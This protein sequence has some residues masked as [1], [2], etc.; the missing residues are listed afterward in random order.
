MKITFLSPYLNMGGG[1]KVVSIYADF[2]K[3]AGHEVL[4][5][6]MPA[7]MPT[8][9]QRIKGLTAL[10]F[11]NKTHTCSYFDD[12]DLNIHM[13]NKNRPI[14]TSD[15]PDADIIIATWW[16]TAE[17]LEKIDVKKGK[18]VYLIQGYEVF[19][20]VPVS[21]AEAT[22]KTNSHKVVVSKWLKNII[23]TKYGN[24]HVDLVYNAIE[25]QYFSYLERDKNI[26][27]TIG[28][29]MNESSVKG[30]DVAF[31]VIEKLKAIYPK[32]RVLSFGSS[33]VAESNIKNIEFTQLP[34]AQ[35]IADI[36]HHCDVWLSASRS[37]GF[38][39]TVMEAMACGTPVVCTKAGW[40]IE[41]IKQYENGFITEVD[42][43]D[44]LVDGIKW[45]LNLSNDNW[46]SV[47]EKAAST[48]NDYSWEKSANQ[49]EQILFNQS[50]K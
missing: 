17:W 22:Y 10:E 48:T 49:F 6:T 36:Y 5:V 46:K 21:R 33:K 1:T 44:G 37:E 41:A 42:N 23:E 26:N 8:I 30:L 4:I 2:L 28:F 38:N 35:K 29:L 39:L 43:V 15:L 50:Q 12:L 9:K 20:Y 32:L 45:V 40:P 24:N 47:A 31:K 18:K 27:P 19:D 25:K 13:L 3:K 34:T 14:T 11:R 16:E 7:P